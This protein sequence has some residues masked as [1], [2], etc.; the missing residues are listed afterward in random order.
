VLLS[1]LLAI[2]S[3]VAQ[4]LFDE[5]ISEKGRKEAEKYEDIY[6]MNNLKDLL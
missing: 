1:Q 3:A 2:Y 4:D 6:V 5:C